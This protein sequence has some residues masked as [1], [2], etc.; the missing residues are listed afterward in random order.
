MSAESKQKIIGVALGVCIVCS[1]LVS[2]AAV[3]LN[4]I[5]QRNKKLDKI[6]NIL[7][8][9]SISKMSLMI[10]SWE[11][12]FHRPLILLRLSECPNICQSIL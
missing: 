9:G 1:I 10:Q 4:A 8:A 7:Q 12:V 3:S 6:K 11:K 5:Q 2:T